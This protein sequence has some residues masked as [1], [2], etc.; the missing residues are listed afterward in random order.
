MACK[1]YEQAQD[2]FLNG[3][4]LNPNNVEIKKK[5]AVS[6]L[7]ISS[8]KISIIYSNYNYY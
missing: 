7:K 4:K 8:L 5:L 2:S 3:L 6:R 1:L